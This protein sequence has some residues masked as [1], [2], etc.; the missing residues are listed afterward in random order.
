MLQLSPPSPCLVTTE[1]AH[2]GKNYSLTICRKHCEAIRM[3]HVYGKKA[4]TVALARLIQN[5][6]ANINISLLNDFLGD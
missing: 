5:L 2:N 1:S 4:L 6:Q 3:Q